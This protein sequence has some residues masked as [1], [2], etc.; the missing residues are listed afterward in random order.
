MIGII[1]FGIIILSFT[2][3]LLKLFLK[4]V[5]IN[6]DIKYLSKPRRR[7]ILKNKKNII[8]IFSGIIVLAGFIK[9]V[10]ER[11]DINAL[12][13]GQSNILSEIILTQEKKDSITDF[14]T[15]KL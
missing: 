15:S 14:Y 1:I 9:W 13:E 11:S 8:L 3:S 4:Y 7:F 12:K 5:E 2:L 6:R 10:S